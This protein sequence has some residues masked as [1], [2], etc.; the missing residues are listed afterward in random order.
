MILHL[1]K[2][3]AARSNASFAI[4][5]HPW[6]SLRTRNS[7]CQR[8]KDSREIPLT[9]RLI[10]FPLWQS[11]RPATYESRSYQSGRGDTSIAFMTALT[12]T[13]DNTLENRL[14]L[15]CQILTFPDYTKICGDKQQLQDDIIMILI[16]CFENGESTRQL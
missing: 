12:A 3:Q 15:R 14:W 10:P 16:K 1:S 2:L 11:L 5:I 8:R 13:L 7:I 9:I 4:S 6:I